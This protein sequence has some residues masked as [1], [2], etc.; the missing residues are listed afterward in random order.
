M[1]SVG[2]R[3]HAVD[4]CRTHAKV[5][6]KLGYLFL[7]LVLQARNVMLIRSLNNKLY[8]SRRRSSWSGYCS[9]N[10]SRSTASFKTVFFDQSRDRARNYRRIFRQRVCILEDYQ[11]MHLFFKTPKHSERTFGI[12]GCAIN[13]HSLGTLLKKTFSAAFDFR[14]KNNCKL[15]LRFSW[16]L[17]QAKYVRCC[18]HGIGIRSI[19]IQQ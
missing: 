13:I 1:E 15:Y 8:V 12:D 10:G 19:E 2:A 7:A 6:S 17:S 3:F 14:L 4:H 18:F 9:Q 16:C 11:I 5:C